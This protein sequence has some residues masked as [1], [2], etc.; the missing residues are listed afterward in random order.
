MTALDRPAIARLV[1]LLGMLGSAHD[2]ERA[3]AG[4]KAHELVKRSGLQWDDLIALPPPV[5]PRWRAMAIACCW[6]LDVLNAKERAFVQSIAGWRGTPS[7]KQL[8]WLSRIFEG[9]P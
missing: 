2:G 9:L 7:A 5:G 6:H 1:K 3:A 4:L 8:A